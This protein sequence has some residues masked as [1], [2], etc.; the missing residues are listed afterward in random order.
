[1][2]QGGGVGMM[3]QGGGGGMMQHGGGGFIPH[4]GGGA[5]MTQQ[6][7]GGFMQHGGLAQQAGGGFIPHQGGGGGS[8][9]QQI[10]GTAQ[11][12]TPGVIPPM[13]HRIAPALIRPVAPVVARPTTKAAVALAPKP[14]IIGTKPAPTP[15]PATVTKTVPLAKV[16]VVKPAAPDVTKAAVAFVTPSVPTVLRPNPKA[17]TLKEALKTAALA[18]DSIQVEKP[19]TP[20]AVPDVPPVLKP[21]PYGVIETSSPFYLPKKPPEGDTTLAEDIREH[22]KKRPPIHEPDEVIAEDLSIKDAKEK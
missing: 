17:K 19:S 8:I 1:M 20:M 3:Q 7:G 15:K 21:R 16:P 5:R 13:Q 12:I 14:R 18:S 4:Q 11:H 22:L 10:H 9:Q 6:A 2:Q